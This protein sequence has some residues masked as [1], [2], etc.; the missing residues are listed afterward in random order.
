[1]ALI[2]IE[3]LQLDSRLAGITLS[4]K[5]GELLGV[6]GPNGAGKSS[7]L[8]CIAGL[9][10]YGGRIALDGEDISR[11]QGLKRA[12][13]VALLPQ[14]CQ[15]AWAL[16]VADVIALGRLP[17]GDE[18]AGLIAQAAEQTGVAEWLDSRVD[19]L[20]G[21][22]Q[23]RVWL[24]RVLAG[25]PEII[26]ADEPL[27]SLDLHYQQRVLEL[28]R[29]HAQGP[30]SVILSIHDLNL[31]AHWCDRLVLLDS[32]RVHALGTPQE[33]LTPESIRQVYQVEAQVDFSGERPLIRVL[34]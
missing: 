14:R 11:C 19:H 17:W 25:Q 9:Q 4:L 12:R 27:A 1:M 29:Q 7:L 6:I 13:R 26:L 2:S 5:P 28:L 3:Q 8:E 22:E 18:D 24:A 20:S 30:R 15:S 34:G 33:V 31:A 16:K 10:A 21:G 32:G 23:A